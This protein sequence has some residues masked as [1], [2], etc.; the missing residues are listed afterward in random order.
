MKPERPAIILFY[1]FLFSCDDSTELPLVADSLQETAEIF[2]ARNELKGVSIALSAPDLEWIGAAGISKEGVPVHSDMQFAIASIT[3]NIVA[4]LVLK[5]E[6]D[7][8]LS[9]DDQIEMYVSTPETIDPSITIRQLL[10]H[11]SGLSDYINASGFIDAL[12]QDPARTYSPG[13]ILSMV[14]Q[15]LY[16]PGEKFSYSNTNYILLGLIIEQATSQ[17]FLNVVRDQL[18]IPNAI[19]FYLPPEEAIAGESVNNW[20]TVLRNG[21]EDISLVSKNAVYSSAWTAGGMWTSANDLNQWTKILFQGGFL[22]D[23]SL[24]KMTAFTNLQESGILGFNG[25]GLGTMRFLS[26]RE[27]IGH[28]GDIF[29]FA[30]ISV[31]SRQDKIAITAL[32]NQELSDTKKLEFVDDLFQTMS[33]NRN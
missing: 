30:S 20:S 14:D 18:F 16:D 32:F 28:T 21:L 23:S 11:Q 3:K 29:G 22:S 33:A 8:L 24:D 5:L 13:E 7:G 15:P 9:I 27:W 1:L 17:S 4:G 19:E 26:T 31:F 10:S 2:I 25:Y 12:F 6:E